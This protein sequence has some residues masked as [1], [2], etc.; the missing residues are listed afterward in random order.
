MCSALFHLR[1]CSA[2]LPI[3]HLPQS[4]AL[5]HKHT[6]NYSPTLH[7]AR[8]KYMHHSKNNSKPKSVKTSA[9]AKIEHTFIKCPLVYCPIGQ[10]TRQPYRLLS[11]IA[12]WGGQE[13]VEKTMREDYDKTS[14]RRLRAKTVK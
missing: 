10:F 4:S 14:K 9:A 11:A 7:H 8:T 3:A 2:L 6:D 1:V 5:L 12:Q 13:R